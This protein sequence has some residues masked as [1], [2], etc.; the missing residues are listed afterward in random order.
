M[1]RGGKA[2]DG[3][4]FAKGFFSDQTTRMARRVKQ[5]EHRLDKLLHEERLEKPRARW[6]MKLAFENA[7]ASGRD[8]L[9][10]EALSVG[11]GA[12]LLH[13]LNQ[14]IR[15][16]ERVALIGANGSGKT[17]LARTITGQLPPLAGRVRLG[18]NVR[19][20][21][22]AQEQERLDPGLNALATL[23]QFS[24]QT[25]TELRNFLHYFLFE[26]NDVFVPVADLSFGER[27]RLMLAM[28]VL[29]GC[30][31]LVLDEPINHL[32]IASRERFEQAL[33]SF[34]GT[35]LVIAHDRYFIEHFAT[36]VWQVRRGQLC[37]YADLADALRGE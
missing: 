18:A 2:D 15:H 14:L 29:Q 22:F 34:E 5:L 10:L 21:Y 8:V 30:N 23:R 19:L 17:T 4:K 28:L 7:P 24:H 31:F 26:G 20:G 9:M 12:P 1:K 16:G 25:D 13:D 11:Y 3:D 33:E 37:A 32:D 35:A 27:A 6:Q 36:R